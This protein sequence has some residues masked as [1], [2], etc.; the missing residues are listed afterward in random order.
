MSRVVALLKVG[1]FRKRGVAG[2]RNSMVRLPGPALKFPPRKVLSSKV[3]NP[4][5]LP[6]ERFPT[7]SGSH[8]K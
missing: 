4:Q 5:E 6:L 3:R 8:T 7:K 1:E 2:M